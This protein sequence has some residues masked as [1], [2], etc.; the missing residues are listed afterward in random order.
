[1]FIWSLPVF[2][3]IILS[4]RCSELLLVTLA[5]FLSLVFILQSVFTEG[6][7]KPLFL[8]FSALRFLR[9]KWLVNKLTFPVDLRAANRGQFCCQGTVGNVQI[10][11]WSLGVM[12][13]DQ[14]YHWTPPLPL[15]HR[16]IQLQR[17]VRL[18]RGEA[19]L[20]VTFPPFQLRG[21]T[22]R[23]ERQ[24]DYFLA[25]AFCC[26]QVLLIK[27]PWNPTG[28]TASSLVSTSPKCCLQEL[29]YYS[30]LA[31]LACWH[32]PSTHTLLWAE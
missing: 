22:T 12:V 28:H 29:A 23:S 8:S 30:A 16:M 26:A 24:L 27:L 31:S 9:G 14:G 15:R 1:M 6:S 10:A 13:G 11:R 21:K 17:P 3:L 25:L 5:S 4:F 18:W 32:S 19:L 2:W 7:L 20:L